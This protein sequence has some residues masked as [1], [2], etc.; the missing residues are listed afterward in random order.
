MALI[1]APVPE[2]TMRTISS[3]GTGH[4][5]SQGD[6]RSVGAPKPRPREQLRV[7]A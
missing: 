7:M 3:A 5:H 1:A 2:L 4:H 6:S